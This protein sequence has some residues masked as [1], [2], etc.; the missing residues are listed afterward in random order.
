[1]TRGYFDTGTAGC[2]FVAYAPKNPYNDVATVFTTAS[3]FA[4]S[5]IATSG[6][7]VNLIQRSTN[8]F[9][10]T[11]ITTNGI[12][13]RL[14]GSGIRVRNISQA[15]NVGGILCGLQIDQNENSSNFSSITIPADP[16]T[17][18]VAQ[19][20]NSGEWSVLVWR[21]TDMGDIDY[22]GDDTGYATSDPKMLFMALPPTGV[23]QRYEFEIVEFWEFNGRGCPEYTVSHADPV[24][25]SRVLDGIQ[26]RPITLSQRDWIDH[27][28]GA[29]VDSIAHS[30]SV[31]KTIEDLLGLAGLNSG[32]VGGLVKGLTTFLAL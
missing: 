5:A 14:V 7:G 20:M 16:R 26:M 10:S 1:M 19:A 25:L 15:L 22:M 12:G 13:V 21:P 2:G 27:T 3:T 28:A 31:A 32:L 4:G 8:Y 29:V 6:A 17:A 23:S 9:S 18:L 11:M 24:G 30:D